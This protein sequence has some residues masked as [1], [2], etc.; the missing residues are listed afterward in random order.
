MVYVIDQY[1][2][3]PN[4]IIH[5]MSGTGF[6]GFT[7]VANYFKKNAHSYFTA[8]IEYCFVL[9]RISSDPHFDITVY[10]FD[11]RNRL[12][13]DYLKN[14]E[15]I[16]ASAGMKVEI[17]FVREPYIQGVVAP[18]VVIDDFPTSN[19]FTLEGLEAKIAVLNEFV[20]ADAIGITSTVTL[21]I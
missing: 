4:N 20:I 10:N 3:L 7:S 17:N 1:R 13:F 12:H 15:E 19:K 9:K 18:T 21:A 2:D 11:E 14:L 5:Y 6:E 8:G 16:A